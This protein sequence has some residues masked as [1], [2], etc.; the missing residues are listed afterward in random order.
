MSIIPETRLSFRERKNMRGR[1]T[2][3][4]QAVL[5]DAKGQEVTESAHMTSKEAAL[6]DLLDTTCQSIKVLGYS[7]H[8]IRFRHLTVIIFPVCGGHWTFA[9]IKPAQTEKE[10]E[11][12]YVAGS[13]TF[14]TQ[15]E[16]ERRACAWLADMAWD[17]EEETSPIITNPEDQQQFTEGVQRTKRYQFLLSQGWSKDEAYLLMSPLFYT[18]PQAR[19]DEMPPLPEWVQYPR[20]GENR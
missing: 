14:D 10:E 7:L 17:N 5:K 3:E 20:K 16:A 12:T 8:L 9:Q 4:I 11:R 19:I 1:K 13:S 6:A 15:R 18:I 2:G